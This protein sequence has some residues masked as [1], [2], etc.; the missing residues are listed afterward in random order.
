MTGRVLEGNDDEIEPKRRVY[1]TVWAVG[2]FFFRSFVAFLYTNIILLY[3]QV[4]IYIIY[5]RKKLKQQQH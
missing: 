1:R 5:N 3:I 2:V 4:I